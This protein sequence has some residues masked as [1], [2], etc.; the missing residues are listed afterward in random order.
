[1]LKQGKK[2]DPTTYATLQVSKDDIT[3]EMGEIWPYP[4]SAMFKPNALTIYSKDLLPVTRTYKPM[5]YELTITYHTAND[6]ITYPRFGTLVRVR[7]ANLLGVW[8]SK[9]NLEM[10]VSGDAN[11]PVDIWY[12]FVR[13]KEDT[14]CWCAERYFSTVLL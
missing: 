6:T 14:A 13:G 2:E 12:E 1:M 3:Y 11:V 7:D 10:P 8:S 4:G 5:D 9:G